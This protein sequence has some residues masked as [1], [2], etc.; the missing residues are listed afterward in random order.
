[1]GQ[2]PGGEGGGA[3][4][5]QDYGARRPCPR[6]SGGVVRVPG[7]RSSRTRNRLG[8]AWWCAWQESNLL[9]HAPQACALSGE[10]QAHILSSVTS[11]ASADPML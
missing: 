6:C 1:M 3:G 7:M 9:P 11:L 4:D 5:S 10:L 8:G 2:G